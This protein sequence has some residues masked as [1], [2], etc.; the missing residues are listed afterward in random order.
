[1]LARVLLFSLLLAA[2]TVLRGQQPALSA[3]GPAQGKPNVLLITLDTVRA[4]RMGFL[5]STRG[6]TPALDAL[7]R[8]SMVFTRAYS[9]APITTVS[10]ATI[11]TGTF[12]PFHHV[13]DFGSPLPPAVPYL[14]DLFK[15]QGYRTAAFVGSLILDP[16]NGTAP[17]FDR[18]FDVYDAGYRLRRPGED[19]YQTIERRGE[20]VTARA[21]QWLGI[22]DS[23]L[24]IR[25][26]QSQIPNP[27]SPWF[28][29]VHL[30]DPHDP[31]DP[32]P[33]LKR[34][35][36]NAPYDGEIAAVDRIV[37]KIVAALGAQSALDRS[38]VVV[39]ADHGEALGGHGEDTHGLFLYDD[40]LHVPLVV[41]LPGRRSAG[42]RV[43]ARVRLADIAPTVLEAAGVPIP[44]AMQGESLLRARDDRPSYAET[45][46]PRRAFGWAPLA[47]WRADRFLFVRAPRPELYDQTADAASLRNLVD[48]RARVADAMDREMEQFIVRSSGASVGATNATVDPELARKLASLGYVSGTGSRPAGASSGVDPK[49]RVAVANALHDAV[50][51]VEDGAF[52]RAIPLLERVT[53]SEPDIPLAQ[54]HLGIARAR[55]RQHARAVAP[56]RKAIALQPEMMLAHYELGV[57]LYETGDLKTAAGHFEVVATRM[58]K[59]AD[60]R[61]SL[62]SVYARIDRVPD[63]VSELRA[64]L[65]L[66]PKHFRANLL[67]G[68]ILTLQGAPAPAIDLLKTATTVQ[69]TSA[70]AHQF[71][72]DAYEKAGRTA[73]AAESRRKADALAKK[74]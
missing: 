7:A 66:E 33:D 5:G 44:A 17:G 15:G 63:A 64:A 59:W 1:M 38:V 13:N 12:P 36:A 61:Y 10:H 25:G 22:R 21:L 52:Q 40:T 16:R 48:T 19:R 27:E 54:L 46:Y 32:P 49:D 24:G 28:L 74:P 73:D 69:P 6:L 31:Y 53:A 34:R 30:F 72:A 23:G 62:G 39:A 29:W 55:Q 56:L 8:E 2:T 37:G 60:A 57:A 18:G 51:A 45:E 58:P 70:E 41:R 9:Q 26:A 65:A 71:L 3:R 4:D 67:L 14:A 35:F 50:V 47:A 42:T 20:E 43:G 68:R 11:L